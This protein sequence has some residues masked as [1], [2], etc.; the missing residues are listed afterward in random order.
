MLMIHIGSTCS[1][2][3]GWSTCIARTT[4]S[5]AKRRPFI[6][7]RHRPRGPHRGDCHPRRRNVVHENCFPLLGR[8]R[9]S[10]GK[11]FFVRS[12]SSFL[13]LTSSSMRY[14]AISRDAPICPKFRTAASCPRG[15]TSSISLARFAASTPNH[16]RYILLTCP[17]W[18]SLRRSRTRA[19]VPDV[20]QDTNTK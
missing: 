15:R 10:S 14:S 12:R 6:T 13:I 11:Q 18:G 5:A 4:F 20:V 1:A 17:D 19:K 8:R 9:P 3:K 2:P 7:A 16:P